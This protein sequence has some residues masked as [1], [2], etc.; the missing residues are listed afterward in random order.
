MVKGCVLGNVPVYG[1]WGAENKSQVNLVCFVEYHRADYYLA[2][3]GLWQHSLLSF[4]SHPEK[5]EALKDYF[6]S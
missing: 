1:L 5:G 6:T 2:F 3:T 4:A